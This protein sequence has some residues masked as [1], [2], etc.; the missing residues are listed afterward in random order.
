MVTTTSPMASARAI[1][2]R[3]SSPCMARCSTISRGCVPRCEDFSTFVIGGGSFSVPRSLPAQGAGPMTVA[4][5][6]PE[7]TRLAAEEFWFDPGQVP[8]SGTKTRAAPN[9][10]AARRALRRDHRRRLHR[11]GGAGPPH[12][13][14]FYELVAARLTPE[15]SFLM[16]VIDYED[17][18]GAL[19]S[20]VLTLREVFPV[21]EVWTPRGAAPHPARAWSFLPWSRGQERTPGRPVHRPCPGPDDLCRPR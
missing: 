21:V 14:E 8:R 4:E 12:T 15:G 18:L 3:C 20:I 19:R 10:D 16:T 5:I 1:C 13:E 2:R 11:R 6:D 17:R 9:A 7:V